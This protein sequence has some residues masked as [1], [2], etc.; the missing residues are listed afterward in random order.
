[1]FHQNCWLCESDLS[2]TSMKAKG[3]K[4]RGEATKSTVKLLESI[5]LDYLEKDLLFIL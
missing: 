1:M 2:K 5:I 3:K 4:L